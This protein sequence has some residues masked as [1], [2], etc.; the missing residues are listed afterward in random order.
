F[1]VPPIEGSAC[2][3]AAKMTRTDNGMGAAGFQGQLTLIP[4]QHRPVYVTLGK[5]LMEEIRLHANILFP[6]LRVISAF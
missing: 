2:P 4:Y 5:G 1:C 3:I 6:S